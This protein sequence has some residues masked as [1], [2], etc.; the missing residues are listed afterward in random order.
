MVCGK[1]KYKTLI[2]LADLLNSAKNRLVGMQGHLKVIENFVKKK[3]ADF[4]N[5]CTEKSSL[6]KTGKRASE[7][8]KGTVHLKCNVLST[9]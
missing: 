3:E 4:L 7:A 9:F 6:H 1:A 8:Y 2:E 5:I